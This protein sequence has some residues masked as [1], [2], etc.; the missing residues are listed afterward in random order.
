MKENLVDL[1]F[2]IEKGFCKKA[3]KSCGKTFW[4]LNPE[5]EYCGDQPCVDYTFIGNPVGTSPIS[6]SDVRSFF[7]KFFEQNDHEPIRRYPVV[8]RWRDD[9][10]LVGA[11]IYDFQPWVTQGI[12][13]PPANPLVISQPS[14]RLTDVDNVGRTGRHLTGFEMMAHHAFNIDDTW[15]YWANETVE[16]AFRVL[17]EMYRIKPEE[18]SFKFDWWSGGG[19]AG[20]DYEVLV[21][22]LEVATLVFMHYKIENDK[23]IPMHNKIVDTGYGLE[24]LAWL[25]K[26][27]PTIYDAIFPEIVKYLRKEAGIEG[28]PSK[29][30]EKLSP[31][32]GRIDYKE[33][34]RVLTIKSQIAELLGI[35]LEE[36]DKLLEPYEYIYAVSDHT[37]TLVWMLGDGVVPSN[38]GAGYLARLL[39]RRSLRYIVKL[40]LELPLS[41]IVLRQVKIWSRDFPEYTELEEM[42][43]EV[44]EYEERK[45]RE[46]LARGKKLLENKIQKLKKSGKS[47]FDLDDLIVLYDSHGI[48]PDLVAEIA[49]KSNVKVSIP[50]DFFSLVASRHEKPGMEF[51]REEYPVVIDEVQYLKPTLALYYEDPELYEFE[52]EVVDVVKGRYIVLDKTCFYPIG[53]GQ[54]YDLGEIV[55]EKGKC[56]VLKVFKIGNV[57]LH[58][59]DTVPFHKGDKVCGYVDKERRLALRRNHTATHIILGAARRVLGFNVWQAG[60]EKGVERSRLDITFHRPITKEELKR[61]ENLANKVVRENRRVKISLVDRNEAESKYGF[62]IYQ[63]GVVPAAKLRIVEIENWDVEACGGLHCSSTGEIG[64]IKIVSTERIQDGVSRLIFKAGEAAVK[65]V[66]DTEDLLRSMLDVLGVQRER[67]LQKLKEVIAENKSL[68]KTLQEYENIEISK[69]SEELLKKAL[70]K[71]QTKIVIAELDAPPDKMLKIAINTIKK[72]PDSL[73]LL[74]TPKGK[75]GPYVIML[76]ENTARRGIDARSINDKLLKKYLRGKGGGKRDLVRGMG[77]LLVDLQQILDTIVEMV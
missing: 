47:S 58:E 44:I 71:N 77:E 26:G 14:I 54:P 53:G 52:A 33:P 57:I 31:K 12:I 56:K 10:Y 27:S 28:L 32:L 60:A 70:V 66:Q 36:L 37:R 7:I 73:V 29:L 3:C 51:K 20:E 49:E 25:F 19:N 74:V 61:I 18:I 17:T 67:A 38:T 35:S 59:C 2:F 15:V 76:G 5:Q 62:T 39:I 4:T 75:A 50:P 13:P 11:S 16:Y 22:G 9:V 48:P 68:R 21:R 45:F 23:V 34:E 6:L 24:R 42:I 1:P 69:I 46:T 8:A 30:V 63:G 65:H 41:E 43:K 55:G 40:G 72:S 64:F